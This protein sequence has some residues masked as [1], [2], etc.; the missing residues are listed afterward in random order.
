MKKMNFWKAVLGVATAML[1]SVGAYGQVANSDYERYDTD[2]QNPDTID[3]VTL[4]T[5][6]S[7]VMGYY[8]LPD[9]VY[10]PAY[11]GPA[12]TLTANFTWDWTVTPAMA[13]AKPGAANYVQVTYTAVGA[14]DITVAEHA[15][16]AMGNCA[17]ATPTEMVVNVIAPP[18]AV[19]TTADPAQACSSQPAMAVALSF[20]EAVPV[21]WAGYAFAVNQ[22]IENIDVAGNPVGL[23]ILDA[24]TLDF[25]TTGKLN[26]GNGLT[27]GASPYGYT[28]NTRDLNVLNGQRTR[29][30]YT[31]VKASDAPAAAGDGLMSAISQKSDYIAEAGGA[32]YL[33]YA[34]T[35][36]HAIV[37]I[38]NPAPS[39]GPIYYVPNNFNY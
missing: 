20:T 32:D 25:P 33:T 11:A 13:T 2:L 3:Y 6:G 39:T 17:D 23:A 29:Y 8:A 36:D 22:L 31:L 14:Y 10:H 16:A 5:G 9:P 26:S 18:A 34:Y 15:P 27:G 1:L 12:W 28:F 21:N 37:I 19:V 7:T 38:V 30:T 35:G 4:R 24:D